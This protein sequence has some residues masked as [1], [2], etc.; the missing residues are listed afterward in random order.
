MSAAGN[1]WKE[2]FMCYYMIDKEESGKRIKEMMKKKGVSTKLLQR[3]L[4]LR[5]PQ[6]IYLW[7]RG[8]SLPSVDSLYTIS[9]LTGVHME[10]LLVAVGEAEVSELCE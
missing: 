4:G 7:L 1:G 10:E 8:K 5:W 2:G 9:R 3:E 6:S